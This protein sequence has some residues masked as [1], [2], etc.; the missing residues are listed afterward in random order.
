MKGLQ[1]K[2]LKVQS[3]W[4][5]H[6]CHIRVTMRDAALLQPLLRHLQVWIDHMTGSGHISG[7]PW[8]QCL[9]PVLWW[10]EWW[11]GGRLEGRSTELMCRYQ[12]HCF[13]KYQA[14]LLLTP[15]PKPPESDDFEVSWS[16]RWEDSQ[17]LV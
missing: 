2:E 17:R 7:S 14:P 8:L 9:Q 13:S 1:K 6:L 5:Q 12:Q 10:H 16:F 15:I 4:M 11:G 3:T